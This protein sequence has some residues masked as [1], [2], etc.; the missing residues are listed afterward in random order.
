MFPEK[1][2]KNQEISVFPGG[3]SN[4]SRLSVF[5]GIADTLFISQMKHMIN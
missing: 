1:P 3:I 4:F 2:I 5:P